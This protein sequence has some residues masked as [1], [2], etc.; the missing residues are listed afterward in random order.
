MLGNGDELFQPPVSYQ[1]G[2]L[3]LSL[4]V[5]L[6]VFNG[7][8]FSISPRQIKVPAVLAMLVGTGSGTFQ[9]AVAYPAGTRATAVVVADFNNDRI[10]DLA[11]SNLGNAI[12]IIPGKGDGHSS[13]RQAP[14]SNPLLLATGDFS[15]DGFVD[16]AVPNSNSKS[17]SI[18]LGKGDGTLKPAVQ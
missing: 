18:Y 1:V 13:R 6:P 5:G 10:A 3:P 15:D 9:N 2:S 14:T 17:V 7:D 16:L 4:A 11:V 8:E 12:S